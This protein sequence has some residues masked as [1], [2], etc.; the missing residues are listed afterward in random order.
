M[1]GD[2]SEGESLQER[3][4]HDG[5]LSPSTR[6]GTPRV[7]TPRSA[8][9]HSSCDSNMTVDYSIV[10]L[11]RPPSFLFKFR[12]TIEVRS[13]TESLFTFSSGS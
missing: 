13:V 11:T 5:C 3:D 10:S 12:K 6:P 1:E 7:V 9:E 2:H 8:E 4:S